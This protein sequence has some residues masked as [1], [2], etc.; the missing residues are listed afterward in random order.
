MSDGIV[1]PQ[2]DRAPQR[3]DRF[4]G[5]ASPQQRR[6][7]RARA[8][9]LRA[10]PRGTRFRQA[11]AAG[12][13]LRNGE[14]RHPGPVGRRSHARQRMG[15]T[16]AGEKRQHGSDRGRRRSERRWTQDVHISRR[17]EAA[18]RHRSRSLRCPAAAPRCAVV[19][20]RAPWRAAQLVRE[21]SGADAF[22]RR[23][24][25]DFHVQPRGVDRIAIRAA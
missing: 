3:G 18:G 21:R 5:P 23:Q 16:E 7:Q 15:Q 10:R 6:G 20:A 13:L 12:A 1:R 2:L 22:R 8:A 9:I 19:E 4:V 11:R 14:R 25:S 17:P 24:A